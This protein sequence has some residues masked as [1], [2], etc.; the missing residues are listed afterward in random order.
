MAAVGGGSAPPAGV[1]VIEATDDSP[2]IEVAPAAVSVEDSDR[3]S[4]NY[5]PL[6]MSEI[7]CRN[8][9]VFRAYSSNKKPVQR[10]CLL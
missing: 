7:G 1:F 10:N 9:R 6:D 3:R 5:L 8:W 4:E 2:R